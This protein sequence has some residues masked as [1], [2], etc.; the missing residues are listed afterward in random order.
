MHLT[1]YHGVFS[2]NAALRAA[3]TPAGRGSTTPTPQHVGL[4]WARRLKRVFGIDVEQCARCGGRL[5]VIASIEEP[6]LIERILAHRREQGAEEASTVSLGAHHH[7]RR[8][9]SSPGHRPRQASRSRLSDAAASSGLYW[10]EPGVTGAPPQKE[11]RVS[12]MLF[13]GNLPLSATEASLV[14]KFARFGTVVSARM[15]RD[16]LTGRTQRSG[17]VEMKT[18]N[19]AQ[20]AINGLNLADYDGRLISV[21]R[22]VAAVLAPR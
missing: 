4:S 7:R 21:Y 1:R 11:P 13:V 9:S 14:V 6:E 19:E 17:F 5:Q 15:N 8:S 3:I 18:A 22:A 12:T 2:A 16:E 10:R 20:V